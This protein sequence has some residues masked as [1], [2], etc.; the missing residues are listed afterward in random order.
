MKNTPSTQL[1]TLFVEL[2]NAELS[3]YKR[4]S[5]NM[6]N[7]TILFITEK[8]GFNQYPI[9]YWYTLASAKGFKYSL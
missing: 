4:V 2:L 9:E 3:S 6:L 7:N 1:Q 5:L 8:H